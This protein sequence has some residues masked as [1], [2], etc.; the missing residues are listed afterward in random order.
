MRS[1]GQP[2]AGLTGSILRK[3]SRQPADQPLSVK[4]LI[5]IQGCLSRAEPWPRL[6]S[7]EVKMNAPLQW[8][9]LALDFV[10]GLNCTLERSHKS[11]LHHLAHLCVSECFIGL[12]S[13][14]ER[15]ATRLR[16]AKGAGSLVRALARYKPREQPRRGDLIPA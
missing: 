13:L 1:A 4:R 9:S 6:R 8:A 12:G 3:A 10:T 7:L 5:I 2:V 14:A 16:P 15:R 11:S